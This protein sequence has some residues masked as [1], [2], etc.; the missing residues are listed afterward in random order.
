MDTHLAAWNGMATHLAAWNGMATHLAACNGRLQASAGGGELGGEGDLKGRRGEEG[1]GS[2]GMGRSEGRS[3][4]APY[5]KGL[6]KT[7]TTQHLV[8]DVIRGEHKA[9]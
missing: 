8:R 9:S 3:L 6:C 5:G 4:P 1:G 7:Y 2:T